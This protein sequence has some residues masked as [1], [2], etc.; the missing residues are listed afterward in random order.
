ML[1]FYIFFNL[2]LRV[3]EVDV[4]HVQ[5]LQNDSWA[6][7]DVMVGLVVEL[8]D[9][10]HGGAVLSDKFLQCVSSDVNICP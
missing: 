8:V 5:V 7:F 2:E 3:K 4:E 6:H 1:L 10:E 9:V